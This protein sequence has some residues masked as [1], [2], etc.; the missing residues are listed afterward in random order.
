MDETSTPLTDD[1]IVT[2][3]HADDRSRAETGDADTDDTD[4]D[5]DDTTPTRTT[6][7]P[8]PIPT[9]RRSTG[10]LARC[11]EPTVG[12]RVPRRGLRARAALRAPGGAGPVRRPPL[13]RRRRADAL[14][15]WVASPCLPT[16]QGG[17]AAG[18]RRLRVRH[19]LAPVAVHGHDRRSARPHGVRER[20]HGRPS[21]ATPHASAAGRLLP[22]ARGRARAAGPG[23]R[24]LHATRLAGPARPPRH[25][26][27]VLPAGRGPKALARL[28]AR[29][30]APAPQPALSPGAG[31]ARRAGARSRARGGRHALHAPRVAARGTDVGRGLAAP[32]DRRQRLHVARRAPGRA[33]RMRGRARCQALGAR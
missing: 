3:P 18:A 26:R 28:R 4:V 25:A 6:L 12:K 8:T 9:T 14:L 33:G 13:A 5:T 24:V 2:T 21:G 16:R 15:R 19:P 11:I 7:T 10:A 27:R 23:E 30:R 32:H 17:G 31:R 22:A 29:A 1:E 20:R